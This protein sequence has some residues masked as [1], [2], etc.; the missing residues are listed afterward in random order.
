MSHFDAAKLEHTARNN[1]TYATLEFVSLLY[2]HFFLRWEF[3]ISWLLGAGI[4]RLF[5]LRLEMR[6]VVS[7]AS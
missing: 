6:L 7:C 2:V 5:V 3:N 4:K 1:A